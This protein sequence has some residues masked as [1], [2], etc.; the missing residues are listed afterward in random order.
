VD[1][2]LDQVFSTQFGPGWIGGDGTYSTALPDGKEAFDFSDTF[3]GTAGPA[4]S[5]DITGLAHSSELTGSTDDLRS[6][7]AGSFHS[8]QSLIPDGRGHGDH[9]EL[10]STYVE[11]GNQLVF[12]NEVAPR[13]GPF[14]RFTG[15]SGIAVLSFSLQDVPTLRSVVPLSTDQRTQWGNA[16]VGIGPFLYVYGITS[17]STTGRFFGTKLA[18]VPSVHSLISQDW[19]YWN[20]VRWVAGEGHAVT[21]PTT[22]TLT[23]VMAQTSQLGF[24]AVSIPSGLT[25]DRTVDLSYA[26]SPQGPWT[27]PTA[28]YAIPQVAHIRHEFAY[29]PTFHPE[30]SDPG[31]VVISYNLDTTDGLG[32]LRHD[33][34]RYQPRFLLVGLGT[35][36]RPAPARLVARTADERAGLS[37]GTLRTVTTTEHGWSAPGRHESHDRRRPG[38]TPPSSLVSS[39]APVGQS[40]ATHTARRLRLD[41][42]WT[43]AQLLANG[44]PKTPSEQGIRWNSYNIGGPKG[45]R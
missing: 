10:A 13:K 22:N 37:C 18:R 12:V 32:V 44:C 1:T 41:P 17:N 26:C 23:G 45:I 36:D 42:M 20:G 34:H 6:D 8:P 24:E 21:I 25:A 28:V 27:V 39:G 9:W 38:W 14:G 35:L 11:G 31:A 2:P 3:I 7:Y 29:I 30:I 5:A 15:R 43:F 33:M 19:Q 16:S 4:G 40:M